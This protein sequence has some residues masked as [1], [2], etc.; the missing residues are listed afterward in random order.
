MDRA[1]AQVGPDLR[2]GDSSLKALLRGHTASAFFMSEIQLVMAAWRRAMKQGTT[3]RVWRENG[4]SN[5]LRNFMKSV[6]CEETADWRRCTSL[7]GIIDLN[8]ESQDLDETNGLIT[9]RVREAWR[10]TRWRTRGRI[11]AKLCVTQTY[12]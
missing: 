1:T 6:G 9:H 5:N 4:W 7:G 11:G 12:N 10:K 2:T 8:P 3:P